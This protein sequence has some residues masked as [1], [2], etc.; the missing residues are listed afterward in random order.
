M[1]SKKGKNV[2]ANTNWP[3]DKKQTSPMGKGSTTG[4]GSHPYAKKATST[5]AKGSTSGAGKWPYAKK[6]GQ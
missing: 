6:G 3:Y 2:P 5:I 4:A 1:A